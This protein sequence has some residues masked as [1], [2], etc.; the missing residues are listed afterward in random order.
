MKATMDSH[1]NN[2]ATIKNMEIHMG[3]MS[4]Q[5]AE[6]QNGQFSINNQTN[7]K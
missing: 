7:P 4:K 3:Q 5:L 6:R 1:E 2:M